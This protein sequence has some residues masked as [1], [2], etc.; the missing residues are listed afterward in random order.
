M[1]PNVSL[2]LILTHTL[3]VPARHFLRNPSDMKMLRLAVQTYRNI[4]GPKGIVPPLYAP[5]HPHPPQWTFL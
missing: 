5:S 1:F 4:P 2:P 3:E